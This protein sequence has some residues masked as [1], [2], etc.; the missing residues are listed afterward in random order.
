MQRPGWYTVLIQ[1]TNPLQQTEFISRLVKIEELTTT[2]DEL[3]GVNAG[4]KALVA[5]GSLAVWQQRAGIDWDIYMRD[6]ADS[7]A[8]RCC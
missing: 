7:N 2:P 4:A 5:R 3:A 6:L 1:L 8:L